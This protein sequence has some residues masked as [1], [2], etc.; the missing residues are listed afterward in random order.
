MAGYRLEKGGLVGRNETVNFTF[1]GRPYV[2]FKGDTLASALVANGVSVFGRSF[3]YHR[4]RG[5]FSRGAADPNTLMQIGIGAQTSPNIPAT[6][7]PVTDGLV[8]NSI[9]AWPSVEFDIGE[10]NDVFKRFLIAG[11][12]YKSLMWPK[13][14]LFEPIIRRA[15]GMGKAPKEPDSASYEIGNLQCDVLVIGA[16]LAGL[17]AAQAAAGA[18][19]DVII[20]E[21]DTVAGGTSLWSIGANANEDVREQV[22]RLVNEVHSSPNIRMLCSTTVVSYHDDNYL[23]AIDRNCDAIAVG[24]RLI[25]ARAGSV[26]VA[27]GAVE[28]P[29]IFENNDRPGVIAADAFSELIRRY[30]VAFGKKIVIFTNGGRADDAI[31]A[32]REAGIEIVAI[33]DSSD[34]AGSDAGNDNRLMGHVIKRAM[35]RKRVRGVEVVPTDG[36]GS[37]KL[38]CDT[39]VVAAGASAQLQLFTQSGGKLSYDENSASFL[40][41]SSMQNVRVCGASNGTNTPTSAV[42][43]GRWAGLDAAASVGFGDKPSVPDL[44]R[45][46]E[47]PLWF[48]HQSSSKTSFVDMQGDVTV[49]DLALALR[50]NFRSIEHI[51]RY[52]TLGMG[53]EQGKISGLAAIGVI[54]ELSGK[55]PGDVGTLKHRPPYSPVSLGA[56][57]AGQKG[58]ALLAPIKKLPA[59]KWHEKQGAVFED[60]G[61]MRPTYY[62]MS[63]ETMHGAAAREAVAVRKNVGLF[64]GTPLGKFEIKGPDAARFLNYIYAGRMDT[65]KVG[66]IRYG[67]MLNENGSLFDDGVVVC[68]SKDHFLINAS[69]G[70]ADAVYDWLEAWHQLE[71][72]LDLVIQDC[73]A[74]WAVATVA[75]PKARE[76]LAALNP[77]FDVSAESFPHMS[78]RAGHISGVPARVQ[79]VSF[80]GEICYEINVSADYGEWIM[81]HVQE[82]GKLFGLVPYGIEAL[83]IL[84][85]EKGYIHVG[86]DTDSNTQPKD[87]GFPYPSKTKESDFIGRRSLM[88]PASHSPNRQQLVGIA[89]ADPDTVLEVGAHIVTGNPAQSIGFI[90]SSYMSPNLGCSIA[91]ALMNGGKAATGASVDVWSLG[92]TVSGTVCDPVFF[93]KE[94]GLLN[95]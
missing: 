84:R 19:A 55:S 69:S 63:G 7:V 65:L 74:E 26:V 31:A 72:P 89:T 79:R 38:A 44:T 12:Y 43:D 18:G 57:S 81:H 92:K 28:R 77:G 68:L 22:K 50:E 62:S 54:S 15:A 3:K 23:V 60:H 64:D 32:A 66:R 85:A 21:S 42:S 11:F 36:Q 35:G 48:V 16:G 58:G 51:K 30:G 27:Q 20:M 6:Q 56:L 41:V 46:L 37:I 90:T 78:Y 71:W 4:S 73:T 87:I 5:L 53:V 40:P 83:E 94:R 67:L 8:A 9:N 34:G 76:V 2:G 80:S 75:G 93:D 82:A 95:G 49:S 47:K 29:F 52:T 14:G 59:H 33:V 88:R 25:H 70:H 13:W 45:A 86:T 10:I 1:N 61:W 17:H 24:E 39:V 91:L